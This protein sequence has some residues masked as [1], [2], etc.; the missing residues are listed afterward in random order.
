MPKVGKFRMRAADPRAPAAHD[1]AA[2]ADTAAPDY[3]FR[4][5]ELQSKTK[6]E[7]RNTILLL[8]LAAQHA[9]EIAMRM[10]DPDARKVFDGHIASIERSLEIARERVADL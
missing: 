10:S 5:A 8:D 2:V 4:F 6:R 7:I 1:Q 3:A 9:R